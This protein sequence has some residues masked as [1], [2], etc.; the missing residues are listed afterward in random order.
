MTPPHLDAPRAAVAVR[1]A[2][3]GD[4]DAVAGLYAQLVRCR[5]CPR[6]CSKSMLLSAAERLDA[7]RFF[8]RRGY[9]GDRKRGF[10]KY[11]QA[12]AGATR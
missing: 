6:D 9:A 4:A 3:A 7:H 5:C 1:R 12:F 10:V 2:R 11:R 8:E